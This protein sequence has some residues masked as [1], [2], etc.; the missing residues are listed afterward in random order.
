V[1]DR[2]TPELLGRLLDEQGG[3]LALFAAQWTENADDC[4]QEAL[5][6]LARQSATPPNVVAWLYRVVR[7][8]AISQYRS[9]R[10]REHRE[11]LAQR[12][13]WNAKP[14]SEA[15]SEPIAAEELAAALAELPDELRECVVARLW[16]E[17]SFEQMSELLGCSISTAYRRYEAG[18]NALRERFELSCPTKTTGRAR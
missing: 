5:I 14:G 17:L 7:N 8:R 6:E 9:A 4:V 1:D 3:A 15:A 12:L 13:K 10:R 18:L 16:G 2:V 11:Q